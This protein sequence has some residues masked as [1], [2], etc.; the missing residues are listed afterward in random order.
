MTIRRQNGRQ[1][2]RSE[3]G[4]CLHDLML[5]RD[6]VTAS[7]LSEK[8]QAA[9]KDV[10][11]RLI[12]QYWSGTS[13]PSVYFMKNLAEVLQL[14]KNEKARLAMSVYYDDEWREI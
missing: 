4:K 2:S 9:G 6:I 7:E 12:R 8:M 3:F 14:S 1:F 13:K 5:S 10:T 11:D